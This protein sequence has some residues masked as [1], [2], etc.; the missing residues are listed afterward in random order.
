M[1]NDDSESSIEGYLSE[2]TSIITSIVNKEIDLG[3]AAF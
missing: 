3:I 2:A 1:I